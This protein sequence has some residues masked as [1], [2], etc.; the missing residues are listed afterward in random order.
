MVFPIQGSEH[1]SRYGLYDVT[2]GKSSIAFKPLSRTANPGPNRIEPVP[3]IS[4]TAV[5]Q[6]RLE[7]S[8]L[9]LTNKVY[10]NVDP[11]LR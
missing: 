5:I 6:R 8:S 9:D 3:G 10:T 2:L 11:V 4:D 7:H 1:I